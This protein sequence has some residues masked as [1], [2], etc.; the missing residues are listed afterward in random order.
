V[1][2]AD[3]FDS[4]FVSQ[5]CAVGIG[6]PGSS[7]TGSLY[8]F[9]FTCVADGAITMVHS[10]YETLLADHD[11]ASHHESGPDETLTIDCVDPAPYPTDTDDDGCPDM[12]EAGPSPMAG[13]QR[14]FLNPND[15]FNPTG[16]G[17]NRIDDV[18]DVV[19]QYFVDEGE[20]G[21]TADTDRTLIGPNAWNLG[22]PNGLQRIDDVVNALSQYFH[23][24]S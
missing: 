10:P 22:A 19:N 24:C 1:L 9:K 14:N 2:D 20:G 4:N 18:V 3:A 13:G 6:S 12:N 8:E 15:Y 5:A 21:Y 17:Q 23:D 16:D 7:Y 11:G